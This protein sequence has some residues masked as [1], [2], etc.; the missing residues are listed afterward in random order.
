MPGSVG[1]LL[2]HC[3]DRWQSL[4]GQDVEV[5]F[6]GAHYRSGMVESTLGD[7]SGLWLAA[8]GVD[9]REFI[10]QASGFK[11]WTSVYPR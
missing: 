1:P 6:Q 5:S 2:T 4:A 10:D 9:Q 8:D 11:I 7:G 3:P